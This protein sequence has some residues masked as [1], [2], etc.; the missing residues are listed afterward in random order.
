VRLLTRKVMRPANAEI[1][2][3]P[4]ARSTRMRAV[5]KL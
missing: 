3:N 1:V 4:M 5:E 2:N